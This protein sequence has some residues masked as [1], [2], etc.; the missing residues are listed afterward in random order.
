MAHALILGASGISGW[1]LLN[2]ARIYPTPTT[3]SRIT[4]TTNRPF[5][6]K[7]AHIPE[8][9]RV[10][11]ASGIDFTESVEEVV[12][13]L[14]EKV[15]DINTVTH[16]FFTA[17]IQT[18]HFETLKKVNTKLLEVAVRAIEAVSPRLKVVVLQTGGKG[19]GLEFPKEV[20]IK[21]PLKETNPRI[22]EPWASNIFYYTQQYDLSRSREVGFSEEIDT[23]E[24][25]IKAWERMRDA[26]ILPIL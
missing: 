20:G 4:G 25:Y 3:F 6:L 2:Q 24:G 1:S 18:N 9:D 17:Y 10:K 22:P 7:Q 16:V 8:D 12:R 15:P 13:A 19:Y 23:V 14:K 26:K 5:T 21:A 11:I